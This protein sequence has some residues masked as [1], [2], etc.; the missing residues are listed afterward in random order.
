[1][2][3]ALPKAG[4]EASGEDSYGLDIP[5]KGI[6]LRADRVRREHHELIAELAV[7][8]ALPGAR[9]VN[10]LA[11]SIAD[12][13]LSSARARQERA[14]LL[15]QRANTR[16]LDWYGVIEE[17]CQKIIE[18]ERAGLPAID[19]REIPRPGPDDSLKVQGF[20]LPRRHPAILFGDGAAGKSY[21]G[22]W[23]AGCLSEQGL[24]VGL[25]DW[26]LAGEDHRD[27]LERLFPDGMPRVLYARCDRP[28][29]HEVD[30]LRRL[31]RDASLE[32]AV[33]DSV[34]FACDGP[35]EAAEV[36]S[37]YFRCVRQIGGGSLHVAHVTK[38]EGEDRKPF[39]SVFW[40]NSARCTWFV[41]AAEGSDDGNTLSLGFFNRKSNLGPLQPPLGFRVDFGDTTTFA[42]TEAADCGSDIASQLSVRQR[43][44]AA[45]RR[46]PLTF[47][48]IAEETDAEVKTV[49]RES[50]RYKNCFVVIPGGKVGLVERRPL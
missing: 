1:M 28:L 42:R 39:G 27:R 44:V 2:R 23:L 32:Y 43:M 12:L 31:A 4:F 36:A 45:L 21:T 13:N 46:G 20:R 35:P 3:A 14:K 17:F 19:L 38:A 48:Q 37:A 49:K 41:K 15:A 26:E 34:A 6:S 40:H 16:D 11:L 18:T 50:Y 9:V 33:Y 24:S 22:L 47:E 25:F 29:V 30:R 8:C 5:G 7:Y 10:G